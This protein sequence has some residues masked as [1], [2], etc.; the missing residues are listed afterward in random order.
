[1]NKPVVFILL[2]SLG[3]ALFM[4]LP[5]LA[6]PPST[7]DLR[8]VGGQNYVTSVKSQQG[9]T[10]WTHGAMASIEGN[11]LMT[12]VWTAAGETGE[13]NMAEYHLDWWNGF[14][15]HNNDDTDPPTG[16]GLVVHEGGDYLVTAA[17]LSRGEGA[18]RDV[19]GQ[20][21]DYAPLRSDTSYHY[22]YVPDIEWYEVGTDLSNINL[23]K[24]KIMDEGVMGTCMCYDGSFI[25]GYVHYQPPTSSLDPNHAIG[26]IGWDDNKV[27]QAAQDGAWLC[28]N[29][30]GE[31][32]G[33]SG[34]FWISYY[35]KHCGHHPEMGAISF[36]D[37]EP[38]QYDKIYYHDYHG[39]RN[40]K[41]DCSEAFN[42]FTASG[43]GPAG[44]LLRSVSFFTADDSVTYTVK[45]YDRFESGQLLDEMTSETGMIEFRGFHTVEL[46]TPVNLTQDDQFFVYLELSHGGQPYDQT[47]DVPVLLGAQ[48]RTIVESSAKPGESYF[49]NGAAWEDMQNFDTTANFCIKAL[50]TSERF[51]GFDFPEGIPEYIEPGQPTS[52][53][54][55]IGDEAAE[56]LPGSGLLHYRYDGG[57]YQTVPLESYRDT[58]LL[59]TLS[60]AL[61]DDTPEFYISAETAEKTVVYCPD[62]APATVFDCEVGTVTVWMEDD[63][64]TNKYW[65]TINAGATSGDWER[66][67]PINDPNWDY[68]PESASGGSGWCYLTQN[69]YGNSDV[70]DGAVELYSPR[71]DMSAGGNIVYDYYLFLTDTDGGVDKL[72]VEI[73]YEGGLGTW[74]EIARH[75][76]DGGLY[77]R[78]HEISHDE[79]V[80]AGVQFTDTMMVRFTVND[81]NPQSV[82][83]AGVD[84][85]MVYSFDCDNPSIC[86]DPNQD[87]IINL[88]D[89][90]FLINYLYREGPEPD[91]LDMS[92]VNN[93][94]TVNI[95]D[96]THLINYL[97]LEGPPPNCP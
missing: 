6:D 49:Y 80:A 90:T 65:S 28:K 30:W 52:F 73:N 40:T 75:D 3:M 37:V 68:D 81:A 54:V 91:P 7:Y 14:N 78:H 21:F 16:G 17:Y 24:Q 5:G 60:A 93:D 10:C 39:W 15:Q 69:T 67:I 76:T 89:V 13:P 38:M 72:L 95:L 12:G 57:I 46:T 8:N 96:I 66:S 33:Y 86:G 64:Q 34:Y 22:Y 61:C 51:L 43:S 59:A 20:S 88:L 42:V 45:V 18:V 85:F 77:W 87:E 26:I 70:D 36:Q 58:M 27:T 71:F 25:S 35:D 55:M 53:A 56:Y 63:F 41:T 94:G 1:M 83:E 31:S 47:S 9:G 50:T 29:S 82:V 4:V 92:D 48:Y 74:I 44:E 84:E 19:D 11:L 23:I 97:Y 79:L 62:D 32:W 2:M